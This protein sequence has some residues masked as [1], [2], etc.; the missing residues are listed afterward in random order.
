[1]IEKEKTNIAAIRQAL[2]KIPEKGFLETKTSKFVADYLNTITELEVTTGIAGTGVVGLLKTGKPGKTL[3]IRADMDALPIQE[4]TGLEFASTHDNMMHACGHD[5]NMSMALVTASI[6]ARL[7]DRF[8]G[9]IKFMFQPAEEWPGGA[10]PMIEAGIMENPHVDYSVACH[11]WPDL[12]AGTLGLKSGILMSATSVFEIE[13]TGKGGHG[14]MPH[15]CVDALDTAVQVV[16]ALQRVVSRKLNPITPSVVT[17]G[18]LHAGETHNI[19]P[20][21]AFLTGTTR[22]FDKKVW[23]EYPTIME[24]IIKGVC[25]SMGASYKF[26]FTPGYPPLVNDPDLVE[27]MKKSMLK[28][29]TQDRIKEQESTMGGEDMSFVFEKS[30]GCYF[31]VGTGFEDCAPLHN[32]KFDFDESLLLPGVETLVRFA[33]DMLE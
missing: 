20:E 18:S 17:I 32:S 15:I 7:K 16:N 12:P 29:V 21:K 14:A 2:H 26:K 25:Q 10:K 33:L 9:N 19:I 6:L 23:N 5:G 1:M 22:T 4:E 30:K 27:L 11:L 13:I 8:S 3:I 28:V 24:P 31:F